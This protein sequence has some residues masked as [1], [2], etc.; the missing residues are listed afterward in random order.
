[1]PAI[2]VGL[3]DD[4]E[5]NEIDHSLPILSVQIVNDIEEAIEAANGCEFGPGSG[6]ISKD[7]RIVERFLREACS[8]VVYVNG[9][10]GIV[11]TALRADMEEFL[12]K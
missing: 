4:H 2:F 6:I 1:M 11:G 12:K 8:D 9:P 10:S 3:P 5:L 7:E